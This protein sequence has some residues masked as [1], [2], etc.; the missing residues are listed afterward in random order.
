MAGQGEAV[1]APE[2]GRL[3]L[4]RLPWFVSRVWHARPNQVQ[5]CHGSQPHNVRLKSGKEWI[6]PNGTG[7]QALTKGEAGQLGERDLHPAHDGR[8][9]QQRA[10]PHAQPAADRPAL[11]RRLRAMTSEERCCAQLHCPTG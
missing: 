3:L 9:A 4:C 1:G 11:H 2:Q 7:R 6:C 5:P 10:H 8:G